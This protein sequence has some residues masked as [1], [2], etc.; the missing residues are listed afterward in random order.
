MHIR[1]RKGNGKTKKQ[2]DKKASDSFLVPF[3]KNNTLLFSLPVFMI[4]L[5][6]TLQ[7]LLKTQNREIP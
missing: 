4:R 7:R 6:L 3:I 1:I 5:M 2:Q